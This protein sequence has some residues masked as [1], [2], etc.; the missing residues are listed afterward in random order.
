MPAAPI[1]RVPTADGGADDLGGEAEI[2]WLWPVSMESCLSRRPATAIAA[3]RPNP[4][5]VAEPAMGLAD[6]RTR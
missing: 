6:L 4:G 5:A 1:A 3:L 2:V